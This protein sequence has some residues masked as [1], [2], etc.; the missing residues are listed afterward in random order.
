MDYDLLLGHVEGQV[1]AVWITLVVH[2]R[3]PLELVM[4]IIMGD[5]SMT[6]IVLDKK[7]DGI[8]LLWLEYVSICPT[9][10]YSVM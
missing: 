1:S 4:K 5:P 8:M 2:F 7:I 10:T 6:S 9:L 3:T